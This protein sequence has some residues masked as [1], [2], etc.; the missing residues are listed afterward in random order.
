MEKNAICPNCGKKEAKVVQR[1]EDFDIRG[2]KI[3]VEVTFSTCTACGAEWENLA[4]GPD[5]LSAVYRAYREKHHMLQP[6]EIKALRK[7]Y[8]LTQG[9]LTKLLGWGQVTLTRYEKGALQDQAHDNALQLLKEPQNLLVLMRRHPEALEPEKYVQLESLLRDLIDKDKEKIF[10][11]DHIFNY[12]TDIFSGHTPFSFEKCL[13]IILFFCKESIFKT[14]LNK[15]MFY[16]DFKHFKN[17][18]KSIT[19]LQYKHLPYGPVPEAYELLTGALIKRREII[20]QEISCGCKPDGIEIMGDEYTSATG[21]NLSVFDDQELETLL[22][23]KKFFAGFGS[24]KISE[25]SHK[26]RAY[27]DTLD[28]DAISYQYAYELN[29]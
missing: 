27:T 1:M 11:L 20:V 24:K 13:N 8:A 12:A 16:A 19:G 2:D 25:F 4:E 6:E 23:V 17:F 21:P 22:S 18:N 9:E 7:K 26:E 28:F 3:S 10:L 29:I 15:L 14:K 5:Y